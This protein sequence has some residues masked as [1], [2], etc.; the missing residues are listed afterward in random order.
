MANQNSNDAINRPVIFKDPGNEDRL[1]FKR[2]DHPDFH[3]SSELKANQ[4]SGVRQN[5]VA[6]EWEIWTLGDLRAHGPIKDQ[7]AFMRAYA[8]V[9]CLDSVVFIKAAYDSIIKP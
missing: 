2:P 3:T 5:S 1:T 9:F 4:F 6:Q 7:D 8:D